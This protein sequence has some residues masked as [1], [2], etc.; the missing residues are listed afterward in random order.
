MITDNNTK[1]K[2]QTG[3][4]FEDFKVGQE[5]IH[6]TPR[7]INEGDIA[8]YIGLTGARQ[9]VHCAR[10]VA[11]ALG[12][13]D[14]PVDD[15]LVFH[16]AFGKTVPDVSYNAVANL[17]YA[18]VRF[19]RPVYAGDTISSRSEVIGL[20]ENSNGKSGI[21]MVRS[22]A[23]NQNGHDVLTWVRWV[24]VHKRDH[25]A[26]AP[27]A[28]W[29]DMPAYVPANQ[30]MWPSTV[31][32]HEFETQQYTGSNY[33]WNDYVVGERI[34]HLAGMTIDETDHTLATKLYQNTARVHFDLHHMQS[35]QFKRRLIYGGHI[36]SVCRALSYNGLENVLN[37]VAIN[38]GA[39]SNPTFAGDTIYAYTEV[40]DKWEMPG[41]NDVGLLRLRLVGVKNMASQEVPSAK[42][43]DEAGKERYH[44]HVVLDLDYTVILPRRAD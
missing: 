15:L 7:T 11:L 16:I 42:I 23:R 1:Q 34:D 40:L 18:D 30:I 29:Q 9:I 32:A 6:A 36:I 31:N 20:R 10:P 33:F 44:P 28:V 22:T 25:N 3:Y 5:L 35:S 12:F 27:E 43:K 19:L 37:I 24:M 39:H 21:V 4:F 8:L 17:G 26:P 14:R 2:S 13:R 38:G 41:R